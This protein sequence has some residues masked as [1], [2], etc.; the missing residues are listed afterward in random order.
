MKLTAVFMGVLTCSPIFDCVAQTGSILVQDF[1]SS[2]AVSQ[3]S[4]NGFGLQ[5]VP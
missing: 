2:V 3:V 1:D 4:G 5:L